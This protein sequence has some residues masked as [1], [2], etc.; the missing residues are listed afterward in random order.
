MK[1]HLSKE[2]L[3]Q[4]KLQQYESFLH[5]LYIFR[6]VSLDQ[7]G[8]QALLRN[9]DALFR[10]TNEWE[11]EEVLYSIFLK[12]LKDLDKVSTPQERSDNDKGSTARKIS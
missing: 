6:N 2:E 11:N 12:N 8:V 7:E 10:N 4:L 5:K 9:L 3:S 1:P